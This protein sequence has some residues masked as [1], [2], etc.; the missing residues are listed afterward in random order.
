MI[1]EKDP[2]SQGKRRVFLAGEGDTNGHQASFQT[3]S[4][5]TVKRE[6]RFENTE[7]MKTIYPC[8][9]VSETRRE[10]ALKFYPESVPW[11]SCFFPWFS[12]CVDLLYQL[13]S[14]TLERL[15]YLSSI[16]CK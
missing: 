5:A 13:L 11:E 14:F 3:V 16:R 8:P 9:N 2:V 10:K 7:L 4:K 6:A 1:I 12:L 15:N